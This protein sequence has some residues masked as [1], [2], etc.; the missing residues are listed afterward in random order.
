MSKLWNFI[1]KFYLSILLLFMYLPILMMMLFSFNEGKSMARWTGFSTHWYV[2]LFE[3][4][5]LMESLGVTLSVAILSSLIAVVIGTIAAIAISEYRPLAKTAIINLT[6]IP[7][8]NADVVT[9]ISM[10]LLFIF[11]KIP[12]GYGTLLISHITFNIPYVI[13]SVLPKL[14]QLDKH[15]YEAALD[16]GAKPLYALRKVIIPDIMPGIV[17]GAI[18]AFTM[19][20]DDFVISYFATQGMV[21]NLSIYIYSMARIGINPSINALSTI[22]FVCIVTLLII[23][24]AKTFKTQQKPNRIGRA[25]RV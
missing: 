22:M 21:S 13:F 7:M 18:M 1:K 5:A 19:S 11:L 20:F 4:P 12:R 3:D 16:L 17:S 25:R 24:N 15:V 10:L 9:G 2:E 6:N 23:S 8:T 14:K